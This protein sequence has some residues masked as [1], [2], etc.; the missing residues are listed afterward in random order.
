MSFD[1]YEIAHARIVD[2]PSPIVEL[3]NIMPDASARI[4]LKYECL[5]PTRAAKD[6]AVKG[7]LDA[8]INLELLGAHTR[9]VEASA[10]A[11]ALAL[12]AATAARG[13]KLTVVATDDLPKERI[14]RLEAFGAELEL[15]P[16][17]KG[18][19]RAIRRAEEIAKAEDDV[20][21]PNL[22]ENSA[23]PTA[24]ETSTAP[25]IWRDLRGRVDV[26][27]AGVGS[28]GAFVGIGRFLKRVNPQIELVA[29][30]PTESAVLSGGRPGAHGIVGLGAGFVPKIFDRRLPTRVA[31]VST[32]E[33]EEWRR[34]LATV[35]GLTVGI[36]TGANLA[37]IAKLARERALLG[38]NV[39]TIAF[40]CG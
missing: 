4:F 11:E 23:N 3:T 36:S 17:S 22:F 15:T 6:R 18:F 2:H 16:S 24:Y 35:E 33:A 34:K 30:E 13:I 21:R 31:T 10:G 12:A 29:V 37:A 1:S 20:W 8:A 14:R 39:A 27:V 38:K 28:G 19:I 7:M 32:D 5:G 40:D 26:F 9:V 25:E